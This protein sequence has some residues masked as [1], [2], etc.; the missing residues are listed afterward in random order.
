MKSN[1]KKEREDLDHNDKNCKKEK[2]DIDLKIAALS[3]ALGDIVYHIEPA[4]KK[5][6]T[7]VYKAIDRA[8]TKKI[9]KDQNTAFL[10]KYLNKKTITTGYKCTYEPIHDEKPKWILYQNELTQ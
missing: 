2:N 3:R 10:E 1:K 9:Y 8:L 4:L 6:Q 7:A 5:A